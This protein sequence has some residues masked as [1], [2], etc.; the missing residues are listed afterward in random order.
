MPLTQVRSGGI[1]NN[2]ITSIKIEAGAIEDSDISTSASI[3]GETA[4]DATITADKTIAANKNV[5]MVGPIEIDDGV[6]ITI[7]ST[8]RL[9]I[10]G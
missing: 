8:S 3:L 7:P 6:T 1:A 4:S 10:L 9:V 5:M 2:A